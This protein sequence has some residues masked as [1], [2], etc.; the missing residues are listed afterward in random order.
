M[1]SCRHRRPSSS[2][3]PPGGQETEAINGLF[4][5]PILSILLK[6]LHPASRVT[7]WVSHGKFASRTSFQGGLFFSS[8][9]PF[10]SFRGAS[11][12]G[13][14]S[15]NLHSG[16]HW[17][18]WKRIASYQ[19]NLWS[20]LIVKLLFIIMQQRLDWILK[21]VFLSARFDNIFTKAQNIY[22]YLTLQG[23]GT[24]SLQLAATAKIGRAPLQKPC[25]ICPWW[26]STW[27]GF[28]PTSGGLTSW[29]DSREKQ[30][31]GG[32]SSKL[33]D[34]KKWRWK[35][36]HKEDQY[37]KDQNPY[38]SS[39]WKD[40]IPYKSN[41]NI[42]KDEAIVDEKPHIWSFCNDMY[43]SYMCPFYC[44]INVS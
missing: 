5:S 32:G 3:P 4:A 25:H 19:V 22:I 12:F 23:R 39:V 31:W 30:Y 9:G 8:G 24:S 6:A 29:A 36:R 7:L 16:G 17:P 27:R 37:G 40:I 11:F 13:M 14:K 33:I 38:Y 35:N 2:S 41:T 21:F 18:P 10:F 44:E 26:E 43:L 20:E 34:S 42:N 1:K 28:G 15:G